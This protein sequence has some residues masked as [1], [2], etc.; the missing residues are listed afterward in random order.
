MVIWLSIQ[1]TFFTF[2][3]LFICIIWSILWLHLTVVFYLH[4]MYAL[5]IAIKLFTIFLVSWRS[6]IWNMDRGRR[7]V[8]SSRLSIFLPR[9][10]ADSG[11]SPSISISIVELPAWPNYLHITSIYHTFYP[12]RA[13][14]KFI[15]V[16][17]LYI[18]CPFLLFSVKAECLLLRGVGFFWMERGSWWWRAFVGLTFSLSLI[19]CSFASVGNIHWS[20][21]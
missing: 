19:L 11:C 6:M 21:F 5:I 7:T 13:G 9:E 12:K 1:Q 10:Q 2:T 14:R 17:F 3:L 18:F 20:F 16:S 8:R 4:K 15:L